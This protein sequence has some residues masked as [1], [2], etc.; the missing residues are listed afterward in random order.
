[1]LTSVAKEKASDGRKLSDIFKAGTEPIDSDFHKS[2]ARRTAQNNLDKLLKSGNA[3]ETQL[4]NY[5]E[6]FQ[7]FD[8]NKQVQRYLGKIN[9]AQRKLTIGKFLKGGGAALGILSAGYQGK[10]FYDSMKPN[11]VQSMY[12]K[13]LSGAFSGE[14]KG[15][16]FAMSLGINAGPGTSSLTIAIGDFVQGMQSR[17]DN[18]I[19]RE[20]KNLGVSVGELRQGY[21]D[22]V[23]SAFNQ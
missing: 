21:L 18:A 22:K 14:G 11:Q 19:A 4:K 12:S 3:S 1:M 23:N 9:N 6:K 20:A 10:K 8:Q 15:F 7:S 16:E 13:I 5:K 2:T 17:V